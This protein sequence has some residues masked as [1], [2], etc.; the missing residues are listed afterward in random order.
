LSLDCISSI[1]THLSSGI[2]CAFFL[3]S[4]GVGFG[5]Q[6]IFCSS[7]RVIF[8]FS[9]IFKFASFLSIELCSHVFSL[10][11]HAIATCSSQS[12]KFAFSL[13]FIPSSILSL[14]GCFC[15]CAKESFPNGVST[16]CQYPFI[17]ICSNLVFSAGLFS[18]T[19]KSCSKADFASASVSIRAK[20]SES[21]NIP[22]FPSLFCFSMMSG[23][24][25]ED[26]CFSCS[27]AQPLRRVSDIKNML[28]N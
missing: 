27:I 28:P 8:R 22:S 7:S 13:L 21:T 11:A 2:L 14:S 12:R 20:I 24:G 4:S 18:T 23:F 25:A 26:C 19:I 5:T 15:I 10:F 6:L 16:A 9:F 1:G 17:Y 3:S